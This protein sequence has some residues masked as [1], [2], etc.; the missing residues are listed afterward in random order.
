MI[1]TIQQYIEA[2]TNSTGRWHTLGRFWAVRDGRGEPVFE[3]AGH[4]LV[5]FEVTDGEAVMTLR[6]PLRSDEA[7]LARLA[8]LA[9]KDAGLASEF[10][11]PWRLLK[12]EIVLFDR[13]GNPFEVDVLIRQAERG[14][15]AEQFL[16]EAAGDGQLA[17]V[18]LDEVLRLEEWSRDV[19]REVSA[20]R[21]LFGEDGSVRVTGFSARGD[22]ERVVARL[23]RLTAGISDIEPFY[24]EVARDENHGLVT[25]ENE[26]RWSLLDRAG[27]SLTEEHYEW[28][29]ECSE[30][31]ILA[32]RDGRCGFLDM[33]GREAIPFIYDDATS[34]V[35]GCAFVTLGG[36]SFFIDGNGNL[37]QSKGDDEQK[38]KLA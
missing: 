5:D 16:Q 20:R 22:I 15:P 24:E 37:L 9:E 35:E 7:S 29:G 4:G 14:M 18:A 12:R 32:Q 30:G 25:V 31:L 13:S 21:L 17:G 1:I 19:G 2:L 3:V 10:F 8:V 27:T 28:I 38:T 33:S 34:F 23:E 36:E 26:G 11:T 6:C